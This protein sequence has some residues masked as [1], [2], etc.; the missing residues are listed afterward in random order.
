MTHPARPFLAVLAS[1]LVLAG[2]ALAAESAGAPAGSSV[3]VTTAPVPSGVVT[4]SASAQAR[5]PRDWMSV[6]F[7]ITRDGSDAGAIQAQLKQALE[8]AL[9]EARRAARPGQVEVAGGAFSL[10]PRYGTRGQ[11]TGWTGST[12]MTVQG[13][14]MAAIAQL[15]GRIGTMTVNRLDYG[16]SP[17]AR[18]QAE[19]QATG[20]AIARYREKAAE[21]AK[22]F[23]YARHELREVSVQSEMPGPPRVFAMKAAAPMAE[24]APLPVEAGDEEVTVSVSGTVQL[25]R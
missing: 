13:R 9:V 7:S 24:A 25:L 3:V 19:A 11:I 14:D 1:A 22:A 15:V 12:T 4:L 17:E 16:L 20:Q 2:P 5:V 18:A 6:V 10:N 23:G 8:A 21:V